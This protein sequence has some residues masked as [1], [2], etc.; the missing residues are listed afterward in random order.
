[1]T[2]LLQKQLD[3]V[4]ETRIKRYRPSR[5]RRFIPRD[6]SVPTW[7]DRVEHSQ[8]SMHG[9]PPVRIA[10]HGPVKNLPRVT[11]SREAAYINI[12]RFGYSYG[13]SIFDLERAQQTNVN[14][15]ATEAVATQTKVETFLDETAAG[16]HLADYGMPGL[17]NISGKSPTTVSTKD[18]GGTVW[19]S[20]G[21]LNATFEEIAG[22]IQTGIEA[23]EDATLGNMQ[24]GLVL[25]PQAQYRALYKARHPVTERSLLA[26][27]R[28]DFP[29]VRFEYWHR[30]AT[31]DQAGTGPRMIV[32][33][34]GEDVARMI[35]P[36]E[37]TDGTPQQ[38]PFSWVIPQWMSTAGML[39]ETPDAIA[40]YDGL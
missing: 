20:G 40:Y 8:I 25:L 21:Q 9:E 4:A 1:M 38:E 14:L 30:L 33:A 22:D 39:I 34:T 10:P 13:Y 36:Q 31:A 12:L 35:I 16:E 24:A 26:R 19:F 23:V 3:Y 17:A 28:E 29:Q 15:P 5:W 27:L 7:A 6:G 37:L 2:L 18:A 11:I 32:M